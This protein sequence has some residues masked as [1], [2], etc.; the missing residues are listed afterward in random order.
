MSPDD[1]SLC[2]TSAAADVSFFL[3]KIRDVR[4]PSGVL[5][6]PLDMN[7]KEA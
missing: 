3:V 6:F 2:V 4:I 1:G 7:A 5:K